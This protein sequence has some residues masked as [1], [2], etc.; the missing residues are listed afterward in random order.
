MLFNKVWKNQDNWITRAGLGFV[1]AHVDY[2]QNGRE[3]WWNEGGFGGSYFSG[4]TSQ[5]AL[6]K[7][8]WESESHFYSFETKFTAS[9]ARVPISDDQRE[10]ADVPNYAI[11]FVFG[12]GS[13]PV[14]TNNKEWTD[15]AK[16]YGYPLLHY[17]IQYLGL[18][19]L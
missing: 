14:K 6:E 7:W 18:H 2:T 17:G 5:I 13:K 12:L 8:I 19:K 3:R 1:F 15:T 4:I 9:F 16:Y 11:H 10:F